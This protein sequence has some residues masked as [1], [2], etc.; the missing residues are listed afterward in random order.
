MVSEIPQTAPKSG[1]STP[2]GH[3]SGKGLGAMVSHAL[4]NYR[5]KEHGYILGLFSIM[6]K[7]SYASQGINKHW[8]KRTKFD[9]FTPEFAHLSENQILMRELY[10]T[11]DASSDMQPFGYR[12][13]Y[14]EY[15]KNRSI[16]TSDF[17]DTFSYWHMAR[18]FS[19]APAL[20]ADFLTVDPNA[21]YLKAPFAVQNEKN[22]LVDYVNVIHAVRPLPVI[23]EPGLVDHF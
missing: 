23:A 21:T 20:N 6:P 22:F 5:V 16:V 2:L 11:G 13:I 14:D 15:R 12:G 7:T 17:R 4:C 18:Q 3:L 1:S 8:L 19:N 9:Y 10:Y